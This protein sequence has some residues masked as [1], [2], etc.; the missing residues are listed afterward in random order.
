MTASLLKAYRSY[1]DTFRDAEGCLGEM[2]DLKLKHTMRVVENAALIADGEGFAADERRA[3]LDAALLHDTGR[4]EQLTRFNTFNDAVSVNHAALS[5]ELVKSFGWLDGRADREA[6]LAAVLY[7]NRKDLPDGLDRVTRRA[8]ET[9]R[10]ADKLDIFH[11]LENL[12]ATTDWRTDSRAFWNLPIDH[13]P[14]PA[15]LAAIR[16]GRACDY[17]DIRSL[18]DFVLIQVGWI[19]SGLYFGV[20]R[21]LA[22]ERGHLAFRRKFLQELG[23]G[24]EADVLCQDILTSA[25]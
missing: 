6:I 17:A 24:P 13:A 1:V 14:N 21:R 20:S 16:E 15:V 8:A 10:D 7:H 23:A 2:L 22:R 3:S 4:Y 12:V 5:H 18:A 11:V 9:V 19:A 25:L